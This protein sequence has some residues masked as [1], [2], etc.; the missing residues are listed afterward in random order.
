M[1]DFEIRKIRTPQ[2]R[3]KLIRERKEHFRLMDQDRGSR[4]R[5]RPARLPTAM[6]RTGP[7]TKF[8]LL[9]ADLPQA[10]RVDAG[11]GRLT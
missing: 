6:P 10:D 7:E 9:K 11:P 4:R 2:E 5:A 3:K 1:D 8:P